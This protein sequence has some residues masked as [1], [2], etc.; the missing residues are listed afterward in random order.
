MVFA[1]ECVY[2]VKCVL[3]PGWESSR[4]VTAARELSEGRKGDAAAAAATLCKCCNSQQTGR[5]VL[6]LRAWMWLLT[7]L[8]HV[9]CAAMLAQYSQWQFAVTLKLIDQNKM[10]VCCTTGQ[11]CVERLVSCKVRRL[12]IL[13]GSEKKKI[14]KKVK[15]VTLKN[16]QKKKQ[17]TSRGGI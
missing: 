11:N 1:R 8:D 5:K 12:F 14:F 16:C 9:I 2:D 15:R 3:S 13:S 6:V 4:S 7:S 17:A 10:M